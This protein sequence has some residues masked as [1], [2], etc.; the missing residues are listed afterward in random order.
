MCHETCRALFSRDWVSCEIAVHI[1]C[2]KHGTTTLIPLQTD[3]EPTRVRVG[4][5][6][7]DD[8]CATAKMNAQLSDAMK[9]EGTNKITLPLGHNVL[10]ETRDRHLLR[11][12]R[13]PPTPTMQKVGSQCRSRHFH[14]VRESLDFDASFQQ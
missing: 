8:K 13:Q 10:L 7:S 1:N 6:T 12:A 4:E 5:V 14:A 9:T 3:L 11:F 2:S